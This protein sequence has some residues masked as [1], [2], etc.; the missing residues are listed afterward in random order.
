MFEGPLQTKSKLNDPSNWH[1]TR[2][3][4]FTH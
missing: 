1:W 4:L 3:F 2:L